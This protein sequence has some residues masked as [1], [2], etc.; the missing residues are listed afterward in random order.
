MSSRAM[1]KIYGSNIASLQSTGP[2]A[3]IDDH[4]QLQD[5]GSGEDDPYNPPRPSGFSI[6]M[7]D[8]DSNSNNEDSGKEQ[9]NST[10]M[11]GN[12]VK[13][14]NK[15]KKKRKKAN[16]ANNS[17]KQD[18]KL[19]VEVDEVEAAVKAV[20]DRLGILPELETVKVD[21]DS[22]GKIAIKTQGLLTVEHRHLNPD[23]EMRRKFG[24]SAAKSIRKKVRNKRTTY[25]STWLT[26]P[27]ETWPPMIKLGLTMSLIEHKNGIYYFTFEHQPDY[28]KI[29]FQFLDAVDTYDPNAI[30]QVLNMYPYHIDSLLQLSE[31][32]KISEDFQMAAQ[33]IERAMYS[34]E[35]TFHPLFNLTQANCRLDYL[36]P[37]NRAF[38]TT[39][40][41]QIKF[42]GQRSCYRTGLELCKL[43]LSLDPDTDPLCVLLMIDFYALKSEEYR[44]LVR[45][46][47]EVEH[48][49]N[50]SQLPNF[51]YSTSIAK[52]YLA[53]E[54]GSHD[55]ADS[56]LQQAL[57]MFP[58]V[59]IPLLDKCSVKFSP[60][61]VENPFFKSSYS[62]SDG[63]RILVNLYIERCHSL[64]KIPEVIDWL[65]NN[66]QAVLK[67]INSND[68]GSKE[69]SEK[70][71]HRYRG[72]PRNI[73]RHV[74]L[75]DI[76]N[77]SVSLPTDIAQTSWTIFD[78]VPPADNVT[79][80]TRPARTRSVDNENESLISLFMRSLM[81]SFASQREQNHQGQQHAAAAAEG[82]IQQLPA[83][84]EEHLHNI[85]TT[86]LDYF[87][88]AAAE[89]RAFAA[90]TANS[91]GNHDDENDQ[92]DGES[93][94]DEIE[95]EV[96]VLD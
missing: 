63:L 53:A 43:L 74:I 27:K 34:F 38:Y 19:S 44:Y 42:V 10:S 66:C 69:L 52:F 5:A 67:R 24:T 51:A 70:R 93:D 89:L 12:T 94:E 50:L 11:V 57:M 59:L 90:N 87:R 14:S 17:K 68:S 62:E 41:Q 91:G 7:N 75:S 1:R 85:Y 77:V 64:W 26:Y 73:C 29:Q 86:T 48:D 82:A 79:S 71:A 88:Q 2:S 78:P 81:P 54:S 18:A 83:G 65:A 46:F 96:N 56:L 9:E 32:C 6:L 37:E 31:I 16:K 25:R 21:D 4:A 39:L 8:Q 47:N 40:F 35:S 3:D 45:I 20:N 55:E 30:A 13:G 22:F 76:K 15:K 36:R 33:L 80:Y 58:M 49:K 84:N 72:I 28:Q 95:D 23:N 92:N 60:D 61:V